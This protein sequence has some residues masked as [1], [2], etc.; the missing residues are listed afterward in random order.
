MQ[1]TNSM[2][3][4]LR[5]VFAD[6]PFSS[7]KNKGLRWK[8]HTIEFMLSRVRTF[9]LSA[10]HSMQLKAGWKPSSKAKRERKSK[11]NALRHKSGMHW[12]WNALTGRKEHFSRTSPSAFYPKVDSIKKATNGMT[13][14]IQPHPPPWTSFNWKCICRSSASTWAICEIHATYFKAPPFDLKATS[15]VDYSPSA[16]QLAMCVC[17]CEC[18][19]VPVCQC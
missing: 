17:V 1:L 2:C 5:A 11:L 13:N 19:G 4:V 14:C 15:T 10:F 18:A 12:K 3:H 6:P 8:K 7:E 16:K 9:N